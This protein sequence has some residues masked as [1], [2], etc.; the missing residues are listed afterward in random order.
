MRQHAAPTQDG[1]QIGVE[2]ARTVGNVELRTVVC[3]GNQIW[4]PDI[5]HVLRI[6]GG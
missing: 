3:L 4:N 5:A 6:R 1:A 2:S